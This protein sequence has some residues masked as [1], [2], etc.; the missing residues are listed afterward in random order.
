MDFIERQ[1]QLKANKT[2]LKTEIIAGIT[3]FM[4]M[5]YIIFVNPSILADAG[6]P[7]E[8]VFMATI[9]GIIL[10]TVAMAFLTNYPFALASGMGLNAF[11]AYTVVIGMGVPWQVALGIIFLEGI[12]FI[13]LSITPVRKMIVNSIPMSLKSAI[14]AG[15]G[16]F[17]AFIG[18]QNAEIIV[19]YEATMVTIGDLSSG[20]PLVALFGTIVM[21]ILY[22]LKVKGSLLWG[23]LA[24]TAFGALPG[25][26]VTPPFEG[27]FAP[28]DFASW[29]LVFGQLDVR[30]AIDIGLIGVI[31]AFLFVDLF[32]TAGT[33]VGVST[34][35]GYLDEDGNLP[36]ANRA[37][38][39]D[40]I[41]TTGGAIFGTSTV[42]TYI[43]SASGVAEGGR[44]GLTGLVTAFLFLLSIFFMP[45][46]GIVPGAATAPALVIVGTMMMSNI[47]KIDW[48]DYTE[49]L[50]AFICMITMPLAYSISHGI[51]LGFIFFPI[52]KVF[53]GRSKE[54]HPLVY[55][56]GA[57][58]ILYFI[59]IE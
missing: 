58:F 38:L 50:P 30:G 49:V 54:V 53:T 4:T 7:W 8:G 29:G 14:A 42:T 6:M 59:F 52:I 39:A 46:V 45:I 13:I 32:D 24:A 48:D 35:A 34:Q 9:A 47:L 37:L 33:L 57:L 21:G 19:G 20:P 51:A 15:I 56:L 1:F 31:I 23:I 36:K 3:T 17:I 25:I 22:A 26:G 16:L 18:L 43:E 55:T 27:I 40:A 44:T 41:G 2:N 5:A 28:P 12:L 10:G 11:F